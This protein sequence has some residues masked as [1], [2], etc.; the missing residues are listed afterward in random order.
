MGIVVVWKPDR[1]GGSVNAPGD[2]ELVVAF[3][4]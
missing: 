4:W 3:D 2:H 1:L